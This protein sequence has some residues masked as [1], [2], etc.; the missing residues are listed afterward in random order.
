MKKIGL[1]L[2]SG[3]ARGLAHVLMFEVFEEL[4]IMPSIISGSSIGAIMGASFASGTSSKEIKEVVND[5]IFHKKSKFWEIHKKSD[6]TKMFNYIDFGFR[7]GGLI[8]GV[9]FLNLLKDEIRV[10]NFE[11][12]KIPLRVVA[13]DFWNH[14]EVIIDSGEI[15]KA[16][17]AS[18]SLPG[19]F[20][21]IE[22]DNKLLFDGGMVNP[23]PY[24]I[25]EDKCDF[26]IAVDVS[27]KKDKNENGFPPSY[28]VLFSSFQIMQNSIVR[29]KL[30]KSQPDVLLNTEIKNVR[31]HEFLKAESI[32]T[33]GQK[34]K[35]TLKRI[36]TNRMEEKNR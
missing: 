25:I 5:L 18:F 22:L 28:E 7:P 24:D 17:I 6:L 16:V 33:Q 27:A 14:E 35:D 4:G 2:G 10:T 11:D 20:P 12:L 3:G 34:A 23:L 8:K 13:T 21:P 15:H 19:L 9:K 31:I 1:A 30:K 36:L 32:Y 29:E 26:T